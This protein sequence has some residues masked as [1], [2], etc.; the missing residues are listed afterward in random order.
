MLARMARRTKADE[1][2]AQRRR[3]SRQKAEGSRQKDSTAGRAKAGGKAAGTPSFDAGSRVATDDQQ[4]S[5][6][7]KHRARAAKASRDR[8]ARDAELGEL[9][10]IAD[11]ARRERCRLDA[12]AALEEYFSAP[13]DKPLSDL[14]R[15]V[16]AFLQRCLLDG[17]LFAQAIFRGF[18]K[19]TIGVRVLVWGIAYG[20]VRYAVLLAHDKPAAEALLADVKS[21]IENNDKLAEDFPELVLPVRAYE[22]K[23]QRAESQTQDGDP[24]GGEWRR[25]RIV[26]PNAL[27]GGTSPVN[28]KR[29]SV[30][31]WVVVEACAKGATRGRRYKL[32]TGEVVR[33]DCFLADD[34]ETTR[35]AASPRQVNNLIDAI[36]KDWLLLGGHHRPMAGI[37]NGTNAARGSMIDQATDPQ[38]D[39]FAAFQKQRVPMVASWADRHDDLWLGEYATLRR[40]FAVDDENAQASAHEAAT[41]YYKANRRAMDA[42]CVVAWE[43]CKKPEE[44]SAIQH[45]YNLLIDMGEEAFAT[46]CQNEPLKTEADL[47]IPP[48]AVIARKQ[49]GLETGVVDPNTTHVVS[50]VDQQDTALYWG[51]GAFGDHLTGHA[52]E[53]GVW[54][55]QPSSYFSLSS[56]PVT[57]QEYYR[58]S[59]DPRHGGPGVELDTDAALTAGLEDLAAYLFSRRYA[60]PGGGVKGIDLMAIDFANGGRGKTMQNWALHSPH[61]ARVVGSYGRGLGPADKTM[62]EWGGQKRERKG[63]EWIE[64]RTD[65]GVRFVL[66][67]KNYHHLGFYRAL[68]LPLGSVGS[69]SLPKVADA[70]QHRLL[71]DHLAA[72]SCDIASS[73]KTGRSMHVFPHLPGRDDHWL[74]VFVNLRVFAM[75]AGALPPGVNR[76]KTA[77]GAFERK[78]KRS[79]RIG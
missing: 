53:Y 63:L 45:A 65:T 10:P 46:E 25:H 71:A 55:E 36:F 15:K 16:V 43:H 33:P 67:N 26:L 49:H 52:V 2:R 21:E 54:P 75:V 22:G 24:T 38:S 76:P 8:Y 29:K 23:H 17:G 12:W 34:V 20:H 48:A 14:H 42:G 18:A 27:A 31:G 1:K 47:V 68:Q 19:T 78:T 41:A 70:A 9:P 64:R 69:F 58:Q 72:S 79:R 57:L 73:E 13:G 74:D 51:V 32:P 30:C 4:L 44:L 50:F 56:L 66:V 7:D 6:A 40:A 35:S 62:A 61:F 59:A 77:P 37:I 28:G 60:I 3:R 39:R 5:A 11:P